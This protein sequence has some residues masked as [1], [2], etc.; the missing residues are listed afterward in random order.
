MECPARVKE[1]L[2]IKQSHL[3]ECSHRDVEM[4]PRINTPQS[5]ETSFVEKEHTSC[6]LDCVFK[7]MLITRVV[8]VML[9]IL[10]V[11]LQVAI[12][13]IHQAIGIIADNQID[14]DEFVVTISKTCFH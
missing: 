4:S 5:I 3:L 6:S 13:L 2:P 8:I 9:W 11:T 1:I 7:L 14:I 10:R 12:K